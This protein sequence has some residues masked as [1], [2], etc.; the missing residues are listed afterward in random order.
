MFFFSRLK[1]RLK[2]VKIFLKK[3]NKKSKNMAGKMKN[4]KIFSE[5]EKNRLVELLHNKMCKEPFSFALMFKKKYKKFLI[6]RSCKFL[7]I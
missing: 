5:D 3:K 7:L 6:F 2:L 1:L 4:F